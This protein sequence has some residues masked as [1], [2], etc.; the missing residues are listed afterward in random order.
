MPRDELLLDYIGPVNSQVIDTLLKKLKKVNGFGNLDKTTGKRVYGIVVECLENIM[1]HSAVVPEEVKNRQPFISV[2]AEKDKVLIKAGNPVEKKKADVL[3]SRLDVLNKSDEATLKTMYDNKISRKV[4]TSENGAGLGLIFMASRSGNIL[5]YQ[6]TPISDICSYFEINVS[7][8]KYIM[9]KLI[10]NQ[11]ASSPGVVLDP[12]KKIFEISGESRP[13]D[14]RE[15][16]DQIISWLNDFSS[17]MIKSE[18]GFGPLE[19]NFNY[20]YFNSSSGKY[21]LDICKILASLRSKGVNI[22]VNWHYEKDDVDMLEVGREMSMIVKFPFE[23]IEN[24]GV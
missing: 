17:Y 8:N 13:P 19:F 20:E 14:V 2:T 6:F 9:K 1:K 4:E 5:N 23:Y 24:K 16:Y 11:T 22:I 21:I 7:L 15:F 18:T 3:A 12:D 10:I